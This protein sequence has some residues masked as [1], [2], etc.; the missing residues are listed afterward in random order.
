MHNLSLKQLEEMFKFLHPDQSRADSRIYKDLRR[1]QLTIDY[2]DKQF[3]VTQHTKEI[4]IID[5]VK[6]SPLAMDIFDCCLGYLI[7]E[8]NMSNYQKMNVDINQLEERYKLMY[9][10][11]EEKNPQYINVLNKQYKDA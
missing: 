4:T 8:K 10:W 1:P 6:F 3:T 5:G 11:L 9:Q 7:N 2:K